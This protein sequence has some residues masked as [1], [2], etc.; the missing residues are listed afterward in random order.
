M[1]ENLIDR[2]IDYVK[3]VKHLSDIPVAVATGMLPFVE[4]ATAAARVEVLEE[5]KQEAARIR[6]KKDWLSVEISMYEAWR[7][8]RKQARERAEGK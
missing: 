1:A 3:S 8:M 7:K 2:M 6:E 5:L 4:Q